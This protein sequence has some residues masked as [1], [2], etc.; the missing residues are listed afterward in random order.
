MDTDFPKEF[1]DIVEKRELTFDKDVSD[2]EVISKLDLL[3]EYEPK[4][5]TTSQSDILVDLKNHSTHIKE[6]ALRHAMQND[7][8]KNYSLILNIMILIKDFT[9]FGDTVFKNPEIY[10]NSFDEIIDIELTDDINDLKKRIAMYFFSLFKSLQKV[11]YASIDTDINLPNF[12]HTLFLTTD[13]VTISGLIAN[14]NEVDFKLLKIRHANVY[15]EAL[16][17]K[18]AL[19]D[20]LLSSFLG[21]IKSERE[22]KMKKQLRN[23]KRK[24]YK[25]PF[26]RRL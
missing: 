16:S 15:V 3:F 4:Y 1:L 5:F 17:N 22:D 10:Y 25:K 24:L 11:E 23:L 8:L 2:E 9:H 12:F 20:A 14:L 21:E 26:S 7:G 13:F 18:Y 19:G 6:V